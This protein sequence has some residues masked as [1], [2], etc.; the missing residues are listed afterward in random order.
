[1][2]P[3]V[4][5]II[6]SR[7]GH[8]D[9]AYKKFVKSVYI[10]LKN[11]NEAISGGTFIGGI[12]TAAAGAA[13]QMIVKGFAGFKIQ[14]EQIYLDP[15]LPEEWKSISFNLFLDGNTYQIIIDRKEMKIQFE[16]R[17]EK[18]S[19]LIVKDTL[20]ALN[21]GET[22]NPILNFFIN[23][24]TAHKVECTPNIGQKKDNCRR[25]IFYVKIWKEREKVFIERMK[26]KTVQ[27]QKTDIVQF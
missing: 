2:S 17:N 27:Y 12:H 10:D 26:N 15:V 25:C 13:W 14:N 1:M 3:S 5:S 20:Y 9:E 16:K 7:T 4:Y 19:K 21:T 11:T 6:A 8:I 24:K 22:I 18:Y 23:Y